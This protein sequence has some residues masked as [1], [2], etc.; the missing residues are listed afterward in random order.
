MTFTFIVAMASSK[1]ASVCL[2]FQNPTIVISA[3][4]VTILASIALIFERVRR[5]YPCNY[6]LLALVTLGETCLVSCVTAQFEP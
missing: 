4:V 1:Y 3:A 5:S 6:A 2:I